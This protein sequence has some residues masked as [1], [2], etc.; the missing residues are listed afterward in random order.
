MKKVIRGLL[1]NTDTAALVGKWDNGYLPTDRTYYEEV[2]YK[3]KTGEY[4]IHGEGGAL[5]KYAK[6]S[7]NSGGGGEEIRPY[8]LDEAKAWSE[9]HLTG[10]HYIKEFGDPEETHG[11]K[12]AL[13][14][15]V[16]PDIK[17]RLERMRQDTGKSIS[18][19]IEDIINAL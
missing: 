1:Y 8:T 9:E 6:W 12:V 15:T 18:Q 19:N 7:G 4:F 2:L 3:K 10:D 17:A 13:N 5:S 16:S 11:S 14:L